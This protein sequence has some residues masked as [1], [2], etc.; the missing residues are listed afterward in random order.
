MNK[1]ARWHVLYQ[2]WVQHIDDDPEHPR[3]A[4]ELKPG[5]TATFDMNLACTYVRCCV[6]FWEYGVADTP[7]PS[8][9]R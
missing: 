3:P 8:S 1:S 9:G 6:C 5:K 7:P 4:S 2:A